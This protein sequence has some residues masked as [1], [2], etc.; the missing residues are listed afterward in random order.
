MMQKLLTAY[1]V[2]SDEER[3]YE[4]DRIY[5]KLVQKSGFDYRRFLQESEDPRSKAKLIFFC[6]L[7]PDEEDY[8]LE[9]WRN[10]GGL[11][12]QLE[13]YL[14]REDWMDCAFIL[15]EELEKRQHYY[16]AFALLT[17]LVR[18]ERR[19]PYFRHFAAVLE[20]TLKE[21]VRLKLR[22]AVDANTYSACIEIFSELGFSLPRRSPAATAI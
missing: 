13:K 1:E 7:R 20:T 10:H 22:S 18:A 2:L 3:R 19:K 9:V 6:L 11:N 8:A 17:A 16:E 12:F 21:L 15:A 14:D 5:I 4:Y